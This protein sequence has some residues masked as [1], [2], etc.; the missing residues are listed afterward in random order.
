MSARHIG[1]PCPKCGAVLMRRERARV[2][3]TGN[4]DV[5]YCAR[6]NGAWEIAEDAARTL[7]VVG[8]KAQP[9]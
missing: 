2:F 6:C 5:A 1:G 7:D 8:F 3:R 4:G 9:A